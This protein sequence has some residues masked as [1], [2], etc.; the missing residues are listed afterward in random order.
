MNNQRERKEMGGEGTSVSLFP[1]KFPFFFY[2][3]SSSSCVIDCWK[4]ETERRII[5]RVVSFSPPP[6]QFTHYSDFGNTQEVEQL[7]FV[8]KCFCFGN[9]F[10]CRDSMRAV[11]KRAAI[12]R[13]PPARP[14]TARKRPLLSCS[15]LSCGARAACLV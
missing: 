11:R 13:R 7:F 12:A 9:G 5:T 14:L 6:I 15:L 2:S 3:F 8:C 4:R 1:Q 10:G